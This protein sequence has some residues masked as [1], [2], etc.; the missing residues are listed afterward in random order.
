MLHSLPVHLLAL[1]SATVDPAEACY[2]LQVI[3]TYLCFFEPEGGCF[4]GKGAEMLVQLPVGRSVLAYRDRASVVGIDD[5]VKTITGTE[6]RVVMGHWYKSRLV[7]GMV[8][9]CGQS[10]STPLHLASC[11]ISADRLPLL[12]LYFKS[13][14]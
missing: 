4:E 10:F 14:Q 13:S 6:G 8:S 12:V 2:H 11:P 9:T 1:H 5:L 3:C 7:F